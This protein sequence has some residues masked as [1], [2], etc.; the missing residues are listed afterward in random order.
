MKHLMM[1]AVVGAALLFGAAP[2]GAEV[3]V[4]EKVGSGTVGVR[5]GVHPTYRHWRHRHHRT[6][7][8]GYASCKV[9]RVRTRLPNGKIVIK[10]RKTC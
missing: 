7:R 4:K 1:G 6:W 3:V 9:V 2:A 10:T 5:V 8:S